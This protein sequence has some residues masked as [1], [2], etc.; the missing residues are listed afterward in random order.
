MSTREILVIGFLA[1]VTPVFLAGTAQAQAGAACSGTVCGLGGQIRSQIGFEVPL[2][3]SLAPSQGASGSHATVG[4]FTGITIQAAP[5]LPAD[6]PFVGQGLGQF[7]QLKPTPDATI[8]QTLDP[9]S[10]PR[11]LTMSPG[12]F[13]YGGSE[14]VGIVNFDFKIFAIQTQGEFDFPH[15]GSTPSGAQAFTEENKTVSIPTPD[16]NVLFAGGRKGAATVTYYA[17]ATASG[18]PSN[19]YGH[20][21]PPTVTVTARAGNNGSPPINGIARFTATRNQFGGQAILRTAGTTKFY[22]NQPPFLVAAADLPCKVTATAGEGTTAQGFFVP[23]NTG[24]GCQFALSIVD[25]VGSDATVGIAGGAFNG[26]ALRSAYRTN[27]GI[28]TGTIG[29]NG[30]II[31]QG[32]AVTAVGVGIPFTGQNGQAVGFPMTTGRLSITVT[33]N[34][35]SSS[36]FIRTGT[37]ARDAA[38]NGVVSLVTGSMSFRDVSL[39]N[40]NRTWVTLEIPEPNSFLAASVGLL[41]L[42]GCYR[43]TER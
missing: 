42:F 20:G 35:A 24:S 1:L 33:S 29:F 32:A 8:M 39:G 30:T 18:S 12:V 34:L 9:G 27:T 2:P 41:A 6:L 5:F 31:G 14:S 3:I 15:P 11:Q 17:D 25:P 43:W 22:F 37:D 38:G 40:G 13:H 21:V 7:G 26:L 19:N 4:P 36:M 23:F 10:G 28:F 16:A